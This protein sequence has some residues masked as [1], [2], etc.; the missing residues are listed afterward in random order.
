MSK[1]QHVSVAAAE[2]REDIDSIVISLVFRAVESKK[3]F[4]IALALS[5]LM[6]VTSETLLDGIK[7]DP[8][9]EVR[10]TESFLSHA[11]ERAAKLEP[12]TS[13][14]WSEKWNL[15]NTDARKVSD[16]R[17]V[18][19]HA[20]MVDAM[21]KR[22]NGLKRELQ[23]LREVCTVAT[24]AISTSNGSLLAFHKDRASGEAATNQICDEF[25]KWME[26]A[27]NRHEPIKWTPH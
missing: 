16:I 23:R 5:A 12:T 13:E 3:N 9:T 4:R 22:V 19:E 8:E 11:T 14:L 24:I 26:L 10:A 7:D 2:L 25:P 20:E 17:T 21:T 6:Q 18:R 1:P 27:K 15:P